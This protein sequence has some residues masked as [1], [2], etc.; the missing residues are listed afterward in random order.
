MTGRCTSGLLSDE[1]EVVQTGDAEHGVVDAVAF[2]AAVAEEYPGLHTSE[3][4][5]DA[6][7]NMFVR[8]VVFLLPLG[9]LLARVGR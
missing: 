1:A 6:G 4:M 3:D 5:F 9:Q 2:E 8:T 7:A